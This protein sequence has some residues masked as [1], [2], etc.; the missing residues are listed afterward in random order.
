MPKE[1]KFQLP[2]EDEVKLVSAMGPVEFS[3]MKGYKEPQSQV[4]DFMVP[5]EGGENI[6]SIM[7][8]EYIPSEGNYALYVVFSIKQILIA[9][10]FSNTRTDHITTREQNLIFPLNSAV[11]LKVTIDPDK[12]LFRGEIVSL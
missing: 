4:A 10:K 6:A 1:L 2:L 11:G 5:T 12:D 9:D 8:R 3:L 7:L